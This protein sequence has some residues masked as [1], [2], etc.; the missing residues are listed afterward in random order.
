MSELD[1]QCRDLTTREQLLT[2]VRQ[3]LGPPASGRPLPID[4]RLSDLGMSSMKMVNLMLS[5]ESE[6]DI[7]DSA[8]GHQPGKLCL[9]GLDRGT[10]SPHPR[11]QRPN[12]H[13]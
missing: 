6:F 13:P 2:L 5:V 4:A 9:I 12:V 7:V 8:V 11:I 3:I 10:D 1:T